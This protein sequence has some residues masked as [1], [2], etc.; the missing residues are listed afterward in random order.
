MCSLQTGKLTVSARGRGGMG[1]VSVWRWLVAVLLAAGKH[2]HTHRYTPLLHTQSQSTCHMSWELLDATRRAPC[3]LRRP[4]ARSARC[5]VAKSW[6]WNIFTL[7]IAHLL[8]KIFLEF[9]SL[10]LRPAGACS[11]LHLQHVGIFNLIY[12]ILLKSLRHRDAASQFLFC[13]ACARGVYA[14]RK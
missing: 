9:F 14:I 4:F 10:L 8:I 1:G 5:K 12:R 6:E 7:F 13:F 2:T 3:P 11:T